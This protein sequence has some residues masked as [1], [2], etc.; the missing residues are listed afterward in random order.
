MT[1]IAGELEGSI[2]IEES[3]IRVEDLANS[4]RHF[5]EKLEEQEEEEEEKEESQIR[6]G[7]GKRGPPKILFKQDVK[8]VITAVKI[9]EVFEEPVPGE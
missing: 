5:Q 4:L 9:E 1:E 8:D 3:P 6:R 7:M 2:L